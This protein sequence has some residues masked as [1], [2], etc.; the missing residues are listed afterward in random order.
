M[1]TLE[2]VGVPQP[3]GNKSGFV[4][5]GRAVLVEGKSPE[6][7]Q[8]VRS[9]RD[10]VAEAARKACEGMTALP[11][12]AG[13]LRVSCEFRL[14]KP[15]SARK[16]DT[17]PATRPD[18]DKLCRLALDELTKIVWRDDGQVCEMRATKIYATGIPGATITVE[19][20]DAA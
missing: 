13:P 6:A 20:L 1:L 16:R 17:H 12:A 8:R 10:A 14:P 19:N 18:C 11:F 7:R 4:V 15:K 5:N 9:W 3:K 2:I